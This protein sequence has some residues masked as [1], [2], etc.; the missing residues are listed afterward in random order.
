M[1]SSAPIEAI[2][3]RSQA[4]IAIIGGSGLAALSE[5]DSPVEKQIATPYGPPSAALIMG[6]LADRS[7]VFLPRHGNPHII[8]PHLVN[9]RANLWALKSLG[10]EKIIAVNAVGGITTPCGPEVV[11]IP[12]QIIDYSY[13]REHTFFDGQ[14]LLEWEKLFTQQPPVLDHVD[15][16]DPYCAEIRYLLINTADALKVPYYSTGVYAS[17]QGPRLESA[18]EI[19]RLQRDGCDIV[20]MT[21]MPEA[22]L[23]RELKI[24]YACLSLVVNWAAGCS[25]DIITMESINRILAQGMQHIVRILQEVVPKL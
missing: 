21:G 12:K 13:G 2:T 22:S 10:V 15:F 25:D 14:G 20:G 18:A 9:Y 1:T 5:L 24:S 23:A 4:P 16:T 11:C 8:P 6:K 17:T 19:A 7:I 3:Q